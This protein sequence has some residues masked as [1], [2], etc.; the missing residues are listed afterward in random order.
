MNTTFAKILFIA[1]LVA[2]TSSLRA[3]TQQQETKTPEE[4]AVE[5][6]LKL[7]RDLKLSD[8]QLFYVDSILQTNFVGQ[9]QEFEKMKASG[10]QSQKSYE[11]VFNKWKTKTEDAFEK[12]LDKTQFEKF[13]KLSGVSAKDRKQRLAK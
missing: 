12:I 2:L 11:D 9:Y 13:L 5:Q 3:Q 1:I 6:A 8:Y 4:T 10:L 7:Q